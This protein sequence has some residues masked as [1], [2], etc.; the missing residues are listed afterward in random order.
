VI[1]RGGRIFHTHGWTAGTRVYDFFMRLFRAATFFAAVF[2]LAAAIQEPVKTEQ[3]QVTGVDGSVAGVR[4]YEGIPFA[5]PPVGDL[6]WRA[7]KA[8]ASWT[9]VRAADHFGS[10]CVQRGRGGFSGAEDCLYLNVYTAAKSASEHHPVMVWIHGGALVSGAGSIYDGNVLA[11][12]GVVVVTVNYR[13]GIFG[14][15]AHPEL[16]KES[17]RNSSGNYGLLDQIAAL[18]WVKKNIAAFG[19]DPKRVT[20]FGQS[21]GSWSVN[22]L[23]ATPLAHGLF[24]RAIGESGAEFDPARSRA[25]MEKAGVKIQES[26]K[27][28]SIADLRGKPAEE[29]AKVPFQTAANVDGWLLPTDVY[30]IYT[31]G[32]QNDV[33]TIA[34]SNNDEGTMFTRNVNAE[35]FKS[36]AER[37]YG[38]EAADFLKVYPFSSDQEAY[39]AAAHAMRDRTFGWE[40]RTWARMQSKTGKSKIYMYYFDHVPPPPQRVKGAYHGAEIAYV[41]GNLL[42]APYATPPG[43]PA[44]TDYDHKLA[45]TMSTYWVNFATTGDPNGKNVPKWPAFKA[46]KSEML[47][48]FGDKIAVGPVPHRPALDFLD[49]YFEKQRQSPSAER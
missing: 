26:M 47:M 38:A 37:Q 41:F 22:Y 40:M 28:N 3:G 48:D 10:T 12:K 45:D 25:D 44:W 34:G 27:A 9:G 46:A 30:T 31:N 7:P 32:K 16:T 15:Y 33:P 29:I 42:V 23:T 4:V 36:Q 35:G 17:D 2:P 1:P 8:P 11:S 18:E 43:T 14:F 24:E 49:N 21:A 20:I 39:D 5:A 13:L 6:R 19:G